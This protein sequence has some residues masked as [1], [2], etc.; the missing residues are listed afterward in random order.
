MTTIQ[1]LS[2]DALR[3]IKRDHERL[4]YEV[5]QLRVMLRACQ[6]QLGD[7]GFKPVC[8]FTLSA[9]LATSDA[10]KAATITQQYGYGR[11]HASTSI[12]L[13]NFLT[14]TAGVY[15]YHGASGAAGKAFYDPKEKKWH[16]FD[17]ECPTS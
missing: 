12:T 13:Q 11:D 8:R 14:K 1:I 17:M 6:S 3:D 5:Q 10:T 9:A 15:E 4:K 16:I 7:D 2:E